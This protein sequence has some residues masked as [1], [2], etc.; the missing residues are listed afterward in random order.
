MHCQ[1][2]R[3]RLRETTVMKKE[4][5][6][7]MGRRYL[8]F[9]LSMFLSLCACV[10]AAAMF[11]GG[12]T[13]LGMSRMR[14]LESAF[15]LLL[16][17]TCL[18]CWRIAQT[19]IRR[20]NAERDARAT[21]AA[22]NENQARLDL[23][24]R[25]ASMGVWHWDILE[26]RRYFDSQ[27][28][29][30]L[31][32][33]EETFRGSGEEFFL[34]VHPDDREVLKAALA[35]TIDRDAM[36]DPEYRVVS[37]DG[38]ILRHVAARGRLARDADGAP[39]R[40]NGVLWDITERKKMEELLR[41][42][43][44]D[45]RNV[46]DNMPAMIGYWD[47]NF[48]NRFG[49][50]AYIEWFGIDPADMPGKHIREVIGEERYELNL[51]YMEAALRGETQVFERAIPTPDGSGVRYSQASYIPD[52]H[53]GTARGFYVLVTDI[54]QVKEAER[55]ADAAS[56]AKSQFLANVS[57]EIR[58]PM[59]GIMGLTHLALQKELTPQLREYLERI[60]SSAHSL[61]GIL[62]DI[63]DIS[64]I[65][66][67][68]L[69]MERAPFDI[70]ESLRRVSGLAAA[71]AEQKGIALSM[72][73]GDDVPRVLTGDPL[74]LEQVLLNLLG[75]AVKFTEQGSV[76]LAVAVDG[77][78]QD[79]GKVVL[80][81][82]VQ[83][84]GIGIRS[85]D[86][87]S[88]FEP[89]AQ[90][91][92]SATRKYGGTGLGLSI[93][94]NLVRMMH[95]DLAVESRHGTG[96]TFSFTAE[97]GLDAAEFADGSSAAP[98]EPASLREIMD[99]RRVLLVED[100][101]INRQVAREML[102]ATGL[103]VDIAENGEQALQILSGSAANYDLVL[104]D[105]QMPVMDGYEAT[106]RIRRHWDR[107]V[108]PVIAMTA[109]AM[110]D[111]RQRCIEA[112]MNDYLSKPIVPATLYT[113]IATWI[114]AGKRTQGAPLQQQVS[115]P[116]QRASLP[117]RFAGIDLGAVMERVDDNI[118][119]VMELFQELDK[120]ARA[121][122]E[123]I[124]AALDSGDVASLRR[125]LHT[126]KGMAGNMGVDG[127]FSTCQKLEAYLSMQDMDRV[128]TLLGRLDNE[129]ERMYRAIVML[130]SLARD[131]A[132]SEKPLQ[133]DIMKAPTSTCT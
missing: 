43:E 123:L 77:R 24:L 108:L 88:I 92:S 22:L 26:D 94:S 12:E 102:Q 30:L 110:S 38:A 119:L 95:G 67:G 31:G 41:Q 116:P 50:R 37:R 99:G 107:D 113:L 70:R 112:G 105:I 104:I 103:A 1:S 23:V 34:V 57:H 68:M 5:L 93:C 35:R 126:L 59:N 53:D 101:L 78:N 117:D 82:S 80:R 46:L 32:L 71:P 109:H 9:P 120:E 84:S 133:H 36:Y 15:L 62:N 124:G 130:P 4:S 48:R 66:A 3:S 87:E 29:A 85:E 25:A 42:R 20:E 114:P 81:F 79:S 76:T 75:N 10:L 131:D 58:T 11:L 49:N 60:D 64:K 21:E 61:L 121:K 90:S 128:R 40:I 6:P 27:V 74:R 86:M 17:I 28:C 100:N 97:F 14:L 129:L 13:V 63:L 127:V 45:L 18:G 8:S 73:V 54:T 44:D 96:S 7:P 65:E 91:D 125:F 39:V 83:D 106:R 118:P 72:I 19:R 111:D 55:A 98:P 2:G 69:T 52:I 33:D 56:R 115:V 132:G 47:R 16:G 122:R 89:F 51:P